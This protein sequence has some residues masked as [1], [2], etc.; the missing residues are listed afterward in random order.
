MRPF[1]TKPPALP[2][3]PSPTAFCANAG[4]FRLGINYRHYRVYRP[5][6]LHLSRDTPLI[7][8]NDTN[9]LSHLKSPS[10]GKLIKRTLSSIHIKTNLHDGGKSK[11]R[12]MHGISDLT[13]EG[14]SRTIQRSFSSLLS[15]IGRDKRIIGNQILSINNNRTNILSRRSIASTT[16]TSQSGDVEK[17]QNVDTR[18]GAVPSGRGGGGGEGGGAR[19]TS[20]ITRPKDGPISTQGPTTIQLSKKETAIFD[21]LDKV[22]EDYE[23]MTG[24]S[25]HLR[26]AG[27]WVRDKLL[28]LHTNDI[29][30]G[31]DKMMGHEFATL[32][33]EDLASRGH[34][35]GPVV[36]ISTNPGK[37]KYLETAVLNI[38][39][40]SVDFANLRSDIYDDS[41]RYLNDSVIGTPYE[42]AHY[43]DFTINALFYN[44]RTNQIEDYTGRGLEDLKYGLIRTPLN[45][46]ETFW[47]DPLRVLRCIRFAG[48]FQFKIANDAMKA[49]QDQKIVEAF[50]SK[51]SK[52]RIGAEMMK[53]LED[54]VGRTT[55]IRLIHELKLYDVIFNPPTTSILVRGTSAVHGTRGDI[56]DAFKMAWIMEWL[57][58]INPMFT[59][60]NFRGSPS[61]F[62]SERDYNR[63]QLLK[64]T[65]G[66]PITS[67]LTPALAT[68]PSGDTWDQPETSEAF[69]E[70]VLPRRLIL[71]SLLYPYRS[72]RA[73]NNGK[74]MTGAE[75]IC[76]FRV[77]VRSNDMYY[78]ATLQNY[79]EEIKQA[80]AYAN[81]DMHSSEKGEKRQQQRQQQQQEEEEEHQQTELSSMGVLI[82]NIG[83]AASI[84]DRW[85]SAFYYGLCVELLPNFKQL[86]QG[87]LDED[88]KAK[89][90]KYNTF[91]S[92]VDEY[93]IEHCYSWKNIISVGI[94]EGRTSSM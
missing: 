58:R 76:K 47:Q 36:K 4:H 91:L 29:D 32:V 12:M 92:K 84:G 18:E 60:R 49:M 20:T 5:T 56:E 46:F 82:K 94:F 93:G 69:A 10:N 28:G 50:R 75:W 59:R 3:L 80:V 64:Q 54:E 7:S 19:H 23:A 40:A 68:E 89:I 55:S 67:H 37:A 72:V 13:D 42:D 57:L 53:I 22:A 33:K 35:V 44:I 41:S 77:K 45:A 78:V 63:E 51:I 87:V 61:P 90:I 1:I 31:V 86:Q 81:E 34:K 17:Y 14:F 70:M 43:R 38:M 21:I 79:V 25:M 26:V 65:R 73:T 83:L 39:G 24:E 8:F 62:K 66:L 6:Q 88:A 11:P 9:T 16:V 48:R 85:P 52:E 71:A 15:P 27:G 74:L 30:I 2:L